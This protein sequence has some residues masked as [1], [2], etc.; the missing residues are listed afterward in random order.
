LGSLWITTAF[1][2]V[3]RT[4]VTQELKEIEIIKK[5]TI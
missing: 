4:A 1:E 5:S 3:A 2:G